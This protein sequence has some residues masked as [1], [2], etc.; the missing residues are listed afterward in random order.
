[1]IGDEASLR[2][3]RQLLAAAVLSLA[4]SSTW[5]GSGCADEERRGIP[6]LPHI[7]SAEVIA[8]GVVDGDTFVA[9]I[10]GA[11]RR[12]RLARIDAPEK[13][14]AFGHRAEQALRDLVWRRTVQMR[15]HQ[16]DR[17]CRPIAEV[18]VDGTDVSEALVRLGMA[19]QYT[20]YSRDAGLAAIEQ[21]VRNSH[22]GLWSDASPIP[23]WEWRR[24]H[25][26]Q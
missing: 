4:I 22:I 24:A 19:W 14:Q 6:R 1:M 23:P 16:V 3:I 17:N 26:K 20:A 25:D 9:D 7:G 12:I 11:P 15:W 10:G 8:A 18:R 2:V 21:Q 5:A 13:R